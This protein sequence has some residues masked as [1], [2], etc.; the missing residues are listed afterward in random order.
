MG[1]L[2]F[3]LEQKRRVRPQGWPVP[4]PTSESAPP[5]DVTQAV[6]PGIVSS[7]PSIGSG[8]LERVRRDGLLADPTETVAVTLRVRVAWVAVTGIDCISLLKVLTETCG[9]PQ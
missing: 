7:R 9:S 1:T 2:A 3:G 5:L 4:H 8:S 6:G